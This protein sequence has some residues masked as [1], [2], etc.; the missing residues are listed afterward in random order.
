MTFESN[1]ADAGGR[2]GGLAGHRVVDT[3]LRAVGRVT[4]V[5][6]DERELGPR[7]AVVKT[8]MLGGE[9]YLPLAQSYLDEDGR[10]VVPHDKASVKHAP[11]ARRDHVLTRETA[12]ELRDYY[13]IAA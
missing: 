3:H 1:T 9:H 5:L 7:W 10:L 12:R 13:G 11:R 2:P 4:D 6:Y 8:G